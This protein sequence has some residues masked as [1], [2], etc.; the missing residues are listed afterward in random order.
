MSSYK[1]VEL[2]IRAEDSE[3]DGGYQRG[4][5]I[6][7]QP[8]GFEWGTRELSDRFIRVKVLKNDVK[9]LNLKEEE[10]D[11]EATDAGTKR[12]RMY[13]RRK[14]HFDLDSL[15]ASTKDKSGMFTVSDGEAPNFI[16]ERAEAKTAMLAAG[17]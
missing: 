8:A 16:K 17:L 10:R 14:R 9:K 6:D 15:D 4:D 5:V 13:Q 1:Y 12:V 7:V 2:L 11:I 3:T